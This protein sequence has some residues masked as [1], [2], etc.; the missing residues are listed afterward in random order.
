MSKPMIVSLPLVLLLLDYWP[1]GRF[2]NEERPRRAFRLPRRLA[3]LILEKAPLFLMAAGSSLATF[4]VQRAGGSVRSFETFPLW[5]RIGNA[6]VA[7]VRY[8]RMLV[9]P[10]NLAIFYPH[11]GTA[12][13]AAAIFGSAILLVAVS[14]SAIALRRRAPF[15]FVGWFWFLVTLLPVIGV[16]QVGYQALADRYTYVPFIGLFT[17]VAWGRCPWPRRRRRASGRTARRSFSTR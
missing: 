8:L 16:V 17:A 4:L 2:R 7:Y 15:F 13:S 5:T 6:L 9:W 12:L 1:L 3:G 14:A 11:P 10:A